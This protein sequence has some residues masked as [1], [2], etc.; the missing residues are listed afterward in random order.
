MKNYTI[1]KVMQGNLTQ[2]GN[3]DFECVKTFTFKDEAIR[4]A[5]SIK[6]DIKDYC[7]KYRNGCLETLVE[8][9]SA[10]DDEEEKLI[11]NGIEIVWAYDYYY[12]DRLVTNASKK[13]HISKQLR[14]DNGL[15]LE[16]VGEEEIIDEFYDDW[17]GA[18]KAWYSYADEFRNENKR[19]REEDYQYHHD[20]LC[21]Y[22]VEVTLDDDGNDDTYTILGELIIEEEEYCEC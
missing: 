1:Y 11:E 22:F 2:E 12:N 14:K 6:N 13:W 9:H 16:P 7:V 18:S 4:F 3:G 20:Y 5:R 19:I 10:D 17:E 15:G 8:V 21:L